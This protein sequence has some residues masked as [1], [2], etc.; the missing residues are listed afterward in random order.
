MSF[1][2]SKVSFAE[3]SEAVGRG[4]IWGLLPGIMLGVLC[5]FTTPSKGIHDILYT[6]LLLT[7]FSSF[8]GGILGSFIVLIT[9]AIKLV[10]WTLDFLGASIL[11]TVVIFSNSLAG[12]SSWILGVS[13]LV[14]ATIL[15]IIRYL[16]DDKEKRIKDT[17]DRVIP[18]I[19]SELIILG[20]AMLFNKI[21]GQ[22]LPFL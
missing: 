19:L 2:R 10:T 7:I 12:V 6:T 20:F 16:L 18:V 8:S 3:F 9:S 21:T 1:D 5:A 17:L 15:L 13:S 11:S 14:L 4:A 22:Q